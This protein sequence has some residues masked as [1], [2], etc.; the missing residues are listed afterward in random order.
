[1]AKKLTDIHRIRLL[2]LLRDIGFEPSKVTIENKQGETEVIDLESPLPKG[3][4]A[5]LNSRGSLSKEQLL[6][7]EE[8]VKQSRE[9]W[10]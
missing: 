6:G 9:D 7:I 1:M 8:S 10:D 4:Q 2:S 3:L 5:V